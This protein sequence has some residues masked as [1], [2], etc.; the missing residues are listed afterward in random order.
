MNSR[1]L[2]GLVG[3]ATVIK[4]LKILVSASISYSIEEYGLFSG[5]IA[6]EIMSTFGVYDVLNNNCQH[7]VLALLRK[8]CNCKSPSPVNDPSTLKE[9]ETRA[10]FGTLNTVSSTVTG[11]AFGPVVGFLQWWGMGKVME[12]DMK[13]QETA[14]PTFVPIRHIDGVEKA[15]EAMDA[16]TPILHL[17][18]VSHLHVLR[19]RCHI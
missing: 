9:T 17:R 3:R 6:N 15:K 2:T 16:D 5:L 13:A 10:A 11:V 1:P 7:F 19:S 12:S 18:K 4:K 8:I 14:H